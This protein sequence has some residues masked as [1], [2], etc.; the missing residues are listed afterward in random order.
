MIY[1]QALY[2]SQDNPVM[3]ATEIGVIIDKSGSTLGHQIK[4]AENIEL[5]RFC[6]LPSPYLTGQ[7]RCSLA[8]RRKNLLCGSRNFNRLQ[9]ALLPKKSAIGS[10]N[11]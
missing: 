11:F 7:A 2:R 4:K 9:N 5:S 8:I 10:K 1:F 6:R 3:A